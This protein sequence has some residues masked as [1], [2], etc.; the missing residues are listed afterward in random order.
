MRAWATTRRGR[1]VWW[2]FLLACGIMLGTPARVSAQQEGV[3]LAWDVNS[4]PAVVGYTVH[5]G[6]SPASYGQTF[7]VP[8]RTNTS[9]R[10]TQ[11]VPG[12]R[13]YFAV[14]AYTSDNQSSSLSNEVSYKI[15]VGPTLTQ[16]LNQTGAVGSAT[17][18]QLSATDDGDPLT[19]S[20]SGL[21][22]GLTINQ[23]TGRISGTPTTAGTFSVN[24]S[25]T[26][27]PLS[28]SRTFSWTINPRLSVTSLT[29]NV[30]S[31]QSTGTAI[32][33]TAAA[34]GGLSPYEYKFLQT[35]GSTTTTLRN[36]GSSANYTWTPT[37]TGSY[38]VTV[39]AR[40]AGV[41]VDA[42]EGSATRN[43]TINGGAAT[44][45]GLSSSLASP[46]ATNTA[47]TFT[48][49]AA[50]GTS[51][52]Q[53]KYLQ[54]LSGNTSTLRDWAASALYTWTPTQT[55][56]YTIT[57]W[58]RS[59]G[60]TADV[61]EA[62]RTLNFTITAPFTL[63][64][65][66][67]NLQMP[68][69][70]GTAITFTA[71]SSG[72]VTPHSY[73]FLQFDGTN[74]TV[75]RNWAT[76]PTFTWTPTQANMFYRIGVWARAANITAD[77]STY[78]MSVPYIITGTTTQPVTITSL[79]SNLAS[80]QPSGT[81][82][83]FT[84]IATGGT[85]PLQY[86]WSVFNG[87]SWTV[88]RDWSQVVNF[89][90]TPTTANPNYQVRLWV[91]SASTTT[92][93]A[94]AQQAIPFVINPPPTS[95]TITSLSSSLPSPQVANTP[96]TF[97]AV[98]SG[99]STPYRYKWWQFNGSTWVMAQNWSTGNTFTWN[100][101]T[102]R[103]NYQIRVWARNSTT[104]TDT[105]EAERAVP[106]VITPPGSPVTITS[107]SSSL[108]SPQ[109]TGTAVTFTAVVSGGTTP[110]QY[111]WFVN[112][113]SAWSVTQNWSTSN[114]FVWTPTTANS[115]YQIRVWARNSTTTTDTADAERSMSYVINTP[116]S[117]VT[118]TSLSSSLPSPQVAGRAIT[119][120]A[121][122]SGGTTP[123]QYK[124][125]VNNGSA[126]SVV[127]N[128]SASNSFVWTPTT[129]NSN[130]Q[131]RVW[132]R[133]STTTADVADAE[134]SV[135]YAIT[136]QP[137]PLT[138][139]SL[140]SNLPSPQAVGTPITFT[141][142]AS[143][144]TSPYQYK[145]WLYAGGAWTVVRNWNASNTFTW[146]PS[147]TSSDYRIGVWVRNANT[148]ADVSDVNLSVPYGVTEQPTSPAL[149]T[150]TSLTSSL[151]SPQAVGRAITF[152]AAVNGGTA[153][154]QYKWWLYNGA[155]WS[156][157]QNWGSSNSYV[158]TPTQ[159]KA[160]YRIGV[161][162]RNAG[163]TADVS[164]VNLSVPYVITPGGS[165]SSRLTITGLTSNVSSPRAPGTTITFTATATGGT[166]PY[167]YKWWL[168]NGA[169]WSVIQNWTS[170]NQYAWTPTQP[171]GNY[172][173]GV[174]VRSATTTAD[175][176]DDNLSVPFAIVGSPGGA[177]Q[178]SALTSNL[179]SPQQAGTA[180][181]FNAAVTGGSGSFHYK[182]WVFD[183]TTWMIVRDWSTAASFSWTPTQANA[184][185]RIG[186]WVRESSMN[187]DYSGVNLST[188]FVVVP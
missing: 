45:T 138:I 119:F 187:T 38:V 32:T 6:I 160:D 44:I 145:W 181:T 121:V 150:I 43:F 16:P 86:K 72:G 31:P 110:H 155:T 24:A 76:S 88:T 67:S 143:G 128:W 92:D 25:V 28:A 169:T 80:P 99:G 15:N 29:S 135:P 1:A 61:A 183:G 136:P 21:P 56:A 106:F 129:E 125:F 48:A 175:E 170:N 140:T 127:R 77:D 62:T 108:P 114:S 30:S 154:Y 54:T 141:A 11:A 149:P 40:S 36:W 182:W 41:T 98:A 58:V 20:A 117:P 162:V 139:T 178:I 22:G 126:W 148:T 113:G 74:W 188:P 79:T 96:I 180:V 12:T 63:S 27:G 64:S 17:S 91:R 133:N 166:A 146:T 78:N 51:P 33:F 147:Q 161:W 168:S 94:D 107:L 130:Y 173:I 144:G 4:E 26:D 53:Y 87:S 164:D 55:G 82:I 101:G 65:L 90:W 152:T 66:T 163:I 109:V 115:N 69:P 174:W 97:T 120:T 84:A 59:A 73:K 134:R 122:A 131:V 124:W 50:G 176:N 165:S 159:A 18:L 112:N 123:Y 52:Y 47:I 111:K 57:V 35:V 177:F 10:F 157:I 116:T 34:T 95:L 83:T 68:Q 137:A 8:G 171:N 7:D 60:Q 103:S 142:A 71:A 5:V 118:I 2:V 49:A 19:Y 186:V 89:T 37:Q 102:P 185:Y 105:A 179:P 100:P 153:P 9:F 184:N 23:S 75:V 39:W 81:S 172:R 132:V 42:A 85:A 167:Q 46:Q 70:T 93:T 151:P 158:W 156:V 13:Y 104:T 14:S 3:S